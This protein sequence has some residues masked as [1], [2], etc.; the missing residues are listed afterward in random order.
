VVFEQGYEC[1]NHN[2]N[3]PKP[4]SD[5]VTD[6]WGSRDGVLPSIQ[7]FPPLDFEQVARE[8]E[9]TQHA[10]GA[11]ERRFP[12]PDSEQEDTAELDIRAEIERRARK[13]GEDY[14]AAKDLYEARIRRALVSVNQRIAI[15]AA[16]ENAL[17]DFGVQVTDELNYLHAP[18]TEFREREQEFERFRRDNRLYRLPVEVPRSRRIVGYLLLALF[19]LLESVLNGVFFA[20]GSEGG[21]IGGV[22]Q[23]LGLAAVNIGPAVLYAL[24]GLPLLYHRRLS[25]K[26]A[27]LL[28]LAAYAAWALAINLVI[29]HF[30]DL[31]IA[32]AG[33]IDMVEM[34]ARLS[35]APLQLE[36][37]NSWL[38]ALLGLGLSIV[39][40]IDTAGLDDKYPQFG[41]LGRRRN[42]AARAYAHAK[43]GCLTGLQATRDG[44]VEDMTSVLHAMNNAEYELTLAVAGRTNLHRNYRAYLEHLADAHLW[45]TRHYREAATKA[46][47]DAPPPARFARAP[48]RPEFLDVGALEEMRELKTDERGKVLERMEHF[49]KEV[50]RKYEEAVQRFQD[51]SEATGQKEPLRA[52]A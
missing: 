12:P 4:L 10:A 40:A 41:A 47:R 52:V 28:A 11:A 17:A 24:F 32:S 29:A 37:P 14:Y 44:A 36:D 16:G 9:L 48:Q 8:L 23:A 35:T 27:G 19:V 34:W 15:E 25:V 1:G 13:A 6:F 3:M 2:K 38:L 26:L 45:L 50:N 7:A 46:R 22:V 33:Q 42:D 5:L 51:L 31:Y 49:I 18:R 20:V 43:N 39:A 21:L 30:R